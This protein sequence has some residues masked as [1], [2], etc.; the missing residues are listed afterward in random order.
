MTVAVQPRAPKEDAFSKI[1]KGLQ[2]AQSILGIKQSF[3]QSAIQQDALARQKEL[4]GREDEKYAQ[5][6]EKLSF[7]KA[8]GLSNEK[9]L[10]LASKGYTFGAPGVQGAQQVSLRTPNGIQT[11]SV[12]APKAKGMTEFERQKLELEKYKIASQQTKDAAQQKKIFSEGSRKLADSIEKTGVA[13]VIGALESLD[14]KID[15]DGDSD[16][17][18]VGLTGGLGT[19]TISEDGKSVRQLVQN[20][21]NT[22]LKARSGGAISDGEA[23]RLMDEL[24]VGLTKSDADLRRGLQMV[25]DTLRTKIQLAES[26]APEES[27]YEYRNRKGAIHSELPLFTKIKAT[28]ITDSDI[29]A[30]I[31]RRRTGATAG[32]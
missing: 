19:L 28:E 15:I 3:D 2:V 9:A 22:L 13:D 5:E 30:E 4:Q 12:I 31:N 11:A 16:I 18:G 17:P 14:K 21:Q 32:F 29:D 10:D 24:G 1:A 8:G 26:G 20:V 27:V 25:R 7:E 23:Q 6:Q